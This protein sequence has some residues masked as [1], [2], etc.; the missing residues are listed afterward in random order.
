MNRVSE[1]ELDTFVTGYC[2]AALWAGLD[3]SHLNE[4]GD[5]PH[6]DEQ[7]IADFTDEALSAIRRECRDFIEGN[8]DDL[9]WA[10]WE[11][12]GY[13]WDHAGHDFYLTRCGHGAGFWDRG[14]GDA[15]ERLSEAAKV[16]GDV[17]LYSTPEGLV[18][19]D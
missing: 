11:T 6:F 12:H 9:L 19:I 4:N 8:E 7:G 5:S 15:G 1:G 18:E 16:Y 3:L 2:E 17:N 13:P 14:L 10:V